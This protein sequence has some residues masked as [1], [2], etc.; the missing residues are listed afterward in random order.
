MCGR[1]TQTIDIEKLQLRFGFEFFME[2]I[3]SI[4]RY[5]I[6]PTQLAPVVVHNEIRLLK[7]FR[8]GLVPYWAKDMKIG[9]KLIN[10]RAETITEK[11][12]F[13][14]PF[15][16]K[17]CLVVTDGFYEWKKSADKK[18][19]SPYRFTLIS[20]EPFAFAGLWDSWK[21]P[22]GDEIES[23]TI[24]TTS[25]NELMLPIHHRMPVI[26]N[27]KDEEKWIDPNYKDTDK[28]IA[29]LKPYDSDLMSAY[30][31]STIVNSPNNDSAECIE[32]AGE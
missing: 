4:P 17:R 32:P 29:L 31:V 2:E 26:L 7:M 11:P 6:A 8:W 14:K 3:D 20:Q 12:S 22:E 10:A 9:S 24:I 25:A 15:K 30:P 5:N 27:Q 21:S 19:K 18:T 16:N 1:Y 13:K 28:L 23:F